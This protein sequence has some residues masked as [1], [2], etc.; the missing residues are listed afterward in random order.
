[1]G[2]NNDSRQLKSNKEELQKTH[3]EY[4]V[5]GRATHYYEAISSASNGDACMA[6]TFTYDGVS[7][8]IATTKEWVATWDTS[9]EVG[10]PTP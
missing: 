7:N 9:W 4:D 5:D 6:T 2:L 1:M 3:T 10:L 8:R